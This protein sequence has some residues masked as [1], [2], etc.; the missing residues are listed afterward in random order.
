MLRS[1][2]ALK[3][4]MNG[5]LDYNDV[6]AHN[7]SNINS[8]GFKQSKVV[9]KSFND[10][11][12]QKIGEETDQ[13]N[14]NDDQNNKYIGKINTGSAIDAIVTDFRQGNIKTTGN[15]LDLAI[16]G[17]GFFK[18]QNTDGEAYTRNGSFMIAND[19]TL[20][21][22]NGD[23]VIC[24]NKKV[25]LNFKKDTPSEITVD[26]G[27]LISVGKKKIGKLDIVDFVD[28]ESL[29]PVGNSLF[30]PVNPEENKPIEA[31]NFKITQGALEGSNANTI[32][33]MVNSINASRMYESMTNVMK[34]SNQALQKT[35]NQVGHI[36]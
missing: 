11:M 8:T 7:M 36:R 21:N 29:I 20:I 9:F 32:E 28:K 10:V 13:Q 3:N 18:V 31:Q 19:G 30:R 14:N 1:L 4:G 34:Q 25:T 27:G 26:S 16:D 23:A 22:S 24:D 17:N 15:P 12:L 33:L 5:I 35:I 2:E 6:L